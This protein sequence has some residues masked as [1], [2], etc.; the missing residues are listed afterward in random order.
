MLLSHQKNTLLN[1]L[2]RF[3]LSLYDNIEDGANKDDFIRIQSIPPLDIIT[4]NIQS[5]KKQL[6]RL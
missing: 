5:I 2:L 4:R 3:E 6:K 1:K